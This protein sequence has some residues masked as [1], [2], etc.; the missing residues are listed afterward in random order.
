M[1]PPH[2]SLSQIP[3][4]P[5]NAHPT[6]AQTLYAPLIVGQI[7]T[8]GYSLHSVLWERGQLWQRTLDAFECLR[9]SIAHV[10]H[11]VVVARHRDHLRFVVDHVHVV[12]VHAFRWKDYPVWIRAGSLRFGG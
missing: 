1:P 3:T 6:K 9:H 7:E 2:S 12:G 8:V 11:V 10:Y 5:I 4:V